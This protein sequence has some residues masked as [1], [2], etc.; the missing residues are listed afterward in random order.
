VKTFRK[1]TQ[2]AEGRLYLAIYVMLSRAVE[3]EL[4]KPRPLQRRIGDRGHLGEDQEG[5]L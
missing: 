3:E 4:Y 1:N 2:L 5:R